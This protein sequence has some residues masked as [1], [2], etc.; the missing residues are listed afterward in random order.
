[1]KK[2]TVILKR[3]DLKRIKRQRICRLCG[4]FLLIVLSITVINSVFTSDASEDSERIKYFTSVEISDGDSL[5]TIADS[6]ISDEYSDKNE[7]IKELCRLNHIT[8]N[9][10]I[11]AGMHL[12]V[13]YY[14]DIR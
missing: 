6:H 12:I 2:T 10:D 9:E 7:Y 14:S 8:M 3:R 1:M 4:L 11:H 13:P 5:W